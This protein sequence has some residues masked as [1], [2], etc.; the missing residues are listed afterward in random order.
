M[1]GKHCIKRR[2]GM[3]VDWCSK[4]SQ[5]GEDQLESC[6][7]DE[8]SPAG[9]P[10]SSVAGSFGSRTQRNAASGSCQG[11]VKKAEKRPRCFATAW[12]A[13]RPRRE[14]ERRRLCKR[15]AARCWARRLGSRSRPRPL[16]GCGW[17]VVPLPSRSSSEEGKPAASH[18]LAFGI[19]HISSSDVR[20][21]GRFRCQDLLNRLGDGSVADILLQADDPHRKALPFRSSRLRPPTPSSAADRN[22]PCRKAAAASGAGPA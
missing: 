19:V 8:A 3:D 21:I 14:R 22:R 4:L 6:I 16:P 20:N 17:T 13:G 2:T 15:A 18:R 1:P 10:V 7:I 5:F 12:R 11:K 9:R